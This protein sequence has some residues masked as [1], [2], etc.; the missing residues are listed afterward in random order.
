MAYRGDPNAQPSLGELFEMG[1]MKPKFD[2]PISKIGQYGAVPTSAPALLRQPQRLEDYPG[3]PAQATA[4]G[5]DPER[6]HSVGGGNKISFSDLTSTKVPTEGSVMLPDKPWTPEDYKIGSWLLPLYGD[7]T[8]AGQT[9]VDVNGIPLR[10][11]QKLGGGG[12]YMQENPD[13]LWASEQ[14]KATTVGKKVRELEQ[15]SGEQVYG[16]HV[17][18]GATGGDFAKMTA[19]TLLQL[20]NQKAISDDTAKAFDALMTREGVKNWPGIKNVGEEW[21]SGPGVGR[22]K[23]AKVMAQARFMNDPA[24]GHVGAVRKAITEPELMHQ[25]MLTS[26][27]SVGQFAP[28]GPNA[29][30]EHESYKTDWLG[31]HLG[32]MGQVPYSVMFNDPYTAYMTKH[33]GNPKAQQLPTLG[34]TVERAMPAQKIT[35]QWQDQAMDWWNL[36]RR[37]AQ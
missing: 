14:G 37:N 22:E 24:F 16:T 17:S 23:L 35:P 11:P 9:L 3:D 36:N 4:K 28:G 30:G 31:T 33:A 5:K 6:F 15:E 8:I 18:M 19:R 2:D 10:N 34:Y 20:T 13:K 27:M 25:P 21:L 29:P 1:F 7:K 12:R 32:N 26:G